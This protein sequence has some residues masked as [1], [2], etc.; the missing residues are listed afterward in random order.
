MCGRNG[1]RV[2]GCLVLGGGGGTL[3][4]DNLVF[5]DSDF[6]VAQAAHE[7]QEL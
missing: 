7:T 6:A 5:L 2:V 3:D 4:F 1:S